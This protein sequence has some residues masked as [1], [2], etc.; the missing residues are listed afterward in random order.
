MFGLRTFITFTDI[1]ACGDPESCMEICGSASGCSNIAYPTLVLNLMPLG[2]SSFYFDLPGNGHYRGCGKSIIFVTDIMYLR[3][4]DKYKMPLDVSFL[5]KCQYL[6][7]L[8]CCLSTTSLPAG[9]NYSVEG[10][11]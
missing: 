2:E 6:I 8:C 5:I 7:C 1:V 4:V 10:E 11:S 3:V 9:V